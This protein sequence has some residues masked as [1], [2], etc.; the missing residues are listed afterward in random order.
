[1]ASAFYPNNFTFF[2]GQ[3]NTMCR[4]RIS[5]GTTTVCG[6]VPNMSRCPALLSLT[7]LA[8]T[9]IGVPQVASA[10]TIACAPDSPSQQPAAKKTPVIVD[11]LEFEG[12]NPLTESE[13]ADLLKKIQKDPDAVTSGPADDDWAIEDIEVFVRGALQDKGYMKVQLDG[14]PYLIRASNDGLHYA[15][16]VEID[17]GPQYRLGQVHFKNSAEGAPLALWE[18]LLSQQLGLK[19]GDLFN[20]SEIRLAMEKITRLYSNHGYIDM[21]PEPQMSIDDQDLRIDLTM[22][23]NEGPDYRISGIELLGSDAG[24]KQQ[25]RLPQ[26]PGEFVDQALWRRFFEDNQSRFPTGAAFDSTVKMIRNV[27]DSTTQITVDL[28]ACPQPGY[29]SDS[30]VTLTTKTGL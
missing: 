18:E 14:T 8:I 23:I 24:A 26:S 11:Q 7:L 13:R 3:L 5:F 27:R 15:L 10:Q 22:N 2:Q 30:N 21:V 6:I 17:G 20:A 19:P 4:H 9:T 29:P 12:D 1:M 16:H 25:I 28:G